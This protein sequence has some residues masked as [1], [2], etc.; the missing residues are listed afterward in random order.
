M[1]QIWE[2]AGKQIST[3]TGATTQSCLLC[4]DSIV[5]VPAWFTVSAAITRLRSPTLRPESV[6]AAAACRWITECLVGA[7]RS[8]GT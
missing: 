2:F 6:E 4:D 3:S 1:A 7:E 5:K 8:Y